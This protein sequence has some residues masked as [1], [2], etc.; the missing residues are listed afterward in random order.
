MSLGGGA[1]LDPSTR[2]Q[3]VELPVVYLTVTAEAVAPRIGDGR[4]PLVRDGIGEWERIFTLRRPIYEELADLT[5]DTS[6]RSYDSIA[7][8][9]AR[10]T[11]Q[12]V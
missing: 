5:I 7:Q 1:V 6:K 12:T 10:W 11:Q 9:V 3:L 2:A 8:E 4:R